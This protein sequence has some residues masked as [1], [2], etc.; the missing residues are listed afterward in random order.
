MNLSVPASRSPVG[1]HQKTSAGGAFDGTLPP[2][3]SVFANGLNK[4][5]DAATGGLFDF[6][7]D[8]PVTVAQYHF[9]L[10]ASVLYTISIVNLDAAGVPIPGEELQIDTNTGRYPFTRTPFI[11]LVRQALKIVAAGTGVRMGQV[12]GTVIKL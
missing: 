12:V 6:K 11:L 9:D 1:I 10:G 4:Y 8:A 3:D 2:G 5:A 7:Q